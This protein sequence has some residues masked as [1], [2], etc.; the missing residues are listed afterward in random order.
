MGQMVTE[1]T[2]TSGGDAGGEYNSTTRHVV[3]TTT[4]MAHNGQQQ[5]SHEIYLVI[6]SMIYMYILYIIHYT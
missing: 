2:L 5:H 4:Q 3:T 6:S 1:L